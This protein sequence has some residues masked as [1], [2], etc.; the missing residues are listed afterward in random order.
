M[1]R[2]RSWTLLAV[3]G[4]LA[5]ATLIVVNQ[6]VRSPWWTYADA[7]ATY[8]ASSLNL[9][10]GNH[11]NYL[12]HPGLPLQ[13]LLGATFEARYLVGH[14]GSRTAFADGYMLHLDRARPYFRGF[15][16]AF[17]LLGALLSCLLVGR[18]LAHWTWGLAAGVLWIAAPGLAAMSIQY[19][20]DVPLSVLVL[21]SGYLIVRAAETRSAL[22]FA[23]AAFMLGLAITV[24]MHAA[25]LLLPLVIAALW[26]HPRDGWGAALR[27]DARTVLRR[28]RILLGALLVLW[29]LL[30]LTFDLERVPFTPTS[31]QKSILT[32]SVPLALY[33]LAGLAVH[34]RIGNRVVRAVLDPFYGLVAW[35]LVAG[36]ALPAT[37]V[38]DDGLQMFVL[39]LK[40]LSGKGINNGVQSF[41]AW[42][43]FKTSL[44]PQFAVFVLGGVASVV[45]AFRRDL[46][47]LLWWSGA[48][49]MGAMAVKRLG[50]LHYFAPSF[51]LSVPAVLWLFRRIPG[52][53]AS[54]LVWPV[55]AWVVWPQIHYIHGAA[56]ERATFDRVATPSIRLVASKLARGEVGLTPSYWFDGDTRYFE[57]VQKYVIHSPEYPYRFL[58]DGP[59]ASTYAA[60]HNL[61]LRYYTGPLADPIGGTQ[62]LTLG[63]GTFTVTRIPEGEVLRLDSGPGVDRPLTHPDAHYDPQTGYYVDPSGAY[64]NLRGD[65]VENPTVRK[66]VG[67]LWLDAYGDFWD[68]KGNLVRSDPSL[69][70]SP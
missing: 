39:I 62:Q 35:A 45:G 56:G 68:A 18:W 50:A 25:G 11:T 46:R 10:I 29:I 15:A 14:D 34:R 55:V 63:S 20:P 52:R 42:N 23:G 9:M 60:D 4:S 61:R 53:A 21:V 58:P 69:R 67:G 36:V 48:L 30:V 24:K 49:V 47:P 43:E 59:D 28:W 12:D 33:A 70:A 8:T 66:L 37:I 6:P 13:E 54:I 40:G 44:R 27:S 5:A 2:L 19:R 16:I 57:L 1:T 22:R 38:L 51:V 32:L 64:W 7:D 3:A 41:H 17:Y 31:A 65:R 26:G